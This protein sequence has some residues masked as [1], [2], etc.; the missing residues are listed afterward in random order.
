MKLFKKRDTSSSLPQGNSPSGSLDKSPSGINHSTQ[1]TQNGVTTPQHPWSSRRISTFNPFPRYG[2]ASN[3]QAGKDADIFVF[4]GL[5]KEKAMNDLWVVNA[6]ELDSRQIA[7][8]GESPSPRVG[9][10]A[11]LIGNAFIGMFRSRTKTSCTF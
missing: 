3:M 6:A 7:T 5:V 9:H 11:L 4:A 10:A 1:N 8:T 2:H